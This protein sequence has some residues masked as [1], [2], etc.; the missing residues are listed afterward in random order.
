MK[1]R[2]ATERFHCRVIFRI[3]F[4]LFA[5]SLT[6]LCC[7]STRTRENVYLKLRRGYYTRGD[8]IQAIYLAL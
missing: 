5:Y 1:P 3:V 4:V 6:I 8:S 7:L 2:D